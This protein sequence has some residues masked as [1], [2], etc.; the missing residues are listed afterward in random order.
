VLLIRGTLVLFP[1]FSNIFFAI[2]FEHL[3]EF[4]IRVRERHL[5]LQKI[6]ANM[7]SLKNRGKCAVRAQNKGSYA[8]IPNCFEINGQS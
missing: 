7:Q 2:N 8:I 6:R 3:T 4:G 5:T 1:F